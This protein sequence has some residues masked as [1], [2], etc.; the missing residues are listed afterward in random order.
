MQ[1]EFDKKLHYQLEHLR[2]WQFS[3]VSD[4]Q[5]Y[6]SHAR[7]LLFTKWPSPLDDERFIIWRDVETNLR[8][9]PVERIVELFIVYVIEDIQFIF[10]T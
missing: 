9:K 3:T 8:M 1:A 10:I 4:L 5:V 6:A 7:F 2:L